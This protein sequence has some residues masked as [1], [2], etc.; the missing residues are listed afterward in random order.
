MRYRLY[1]RLGLPSGTGEVMRVEAPLDEQ[2]KRCLK[3]LR[4]AT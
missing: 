3:V 4:D 2:L 1:S